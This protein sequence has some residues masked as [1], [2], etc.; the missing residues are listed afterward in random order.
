LLPYLCLETI[1]KA[2]SYIL[3]ILKPGLGEVWEDSFVKKNQDKTRS[4]VHTRK[5]GSSFPFTLYIPNQM[6]RFRAATFSTKEPDTL[7]WIDEHGGDG[8]LFDV[9]ANVGLYSLYYA[10]TKRANVYAFEPSFFNLPVLAKNIHANNLTQYIKIV[11]NPLSDA[12]AFA[13]FSLSTLDEGGALS[14]FGVD[15][16]HDGTMLKKLLA[17]KTLGFSLDSMFALGILKEHPKLIKIDVDG[18]EHLILSGAKA[19]LAHPACRS[20]LIETTD[21]FTEK[22][23]GIRAILEGA[24]FSL[25]KA[26]SKD[27]PAGAD[28]NQIWLK[29]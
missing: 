3:N 7:A 27:V 6:C 9:G 20:V 8:V 14:A 1:A 19:T 17:Y 12:D 4:V 2:W 29:Q 15:Y 18:I 25:A 21:S 28:Y 26:R 11:A 16:G 10:A 22:A 23:N 5:D 13:D 24:G